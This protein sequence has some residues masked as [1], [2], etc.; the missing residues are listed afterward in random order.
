MIV[1][2]RYDVDDEMRERIADYML[3]HEGWKIR[4][5]LATREQLVAYIEAAWENQWGEVMNHEALVAEIFAGL[6]EALDND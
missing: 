5:K 4:G 1:V 2:Y 6:A 3:V